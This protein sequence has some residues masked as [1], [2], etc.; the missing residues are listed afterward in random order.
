MTLLIRIQPYGANIIQPPSRAA[1]LAARP[2][3]PIRLLFIGVN[4]QRKG[5]SI[6]LRAHHIL[7]QRGIDSQLTVIGCRPEN[8][9]DLSEVTVIPYLDK[10]DP[11]QNEILANSYLLADIFLLPTRSECYGI[12]FCEA[13]AYG[14][15]SLTTATGGVPDVVCDGKNGF[16][17]PV[18]AD[19]SAY[20]DKIEMI[21]AD[22]KAFDDLRRSSRDF[23][24]TRLNWQSWGLRFMAELKYLAIG[25]QGD[26][27]E[28]IEPDRLAKNP[29]P[30]FS[31]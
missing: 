10:N 22:P 28:F 11:V 21:L 18:E 25:R 19:G 7:R 20:A 29:G 3:G 2:S 23:Y 26:L 14:L 5:G 31:E 12:V 15:P 6:A 16:C 8:G 1:A 13:A 17:L 9:A 27:P 4:W 24:E 30:E